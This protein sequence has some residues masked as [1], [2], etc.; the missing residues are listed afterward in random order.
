MN[1]EV[2]NGRSGTKDPREKLQ[3]G[4]REDRTQGGTFEREALPVC[5]FVFFLPLPP[6]FHY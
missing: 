5:G 4:S 6:S 1:I 2:E 3:F